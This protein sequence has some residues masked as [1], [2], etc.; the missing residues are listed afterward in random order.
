M[1][2]VTDSLTLSNA[3]TDVI[4]GFVMLFCAWRISR[5]LRDGSRE[6]AANL[7]DERRLW[8]EFFVFSAAVALLGVV[9]HLFVWP[10]LAER[11]LWVVLY[12]VMFEVPYLLMKLSATVAGESGLRPDRART[13]VF[14]GVSLYVLT[15]GIRLVTGKN[16]IRV[17]ILFAVI[18]FVYVTYFFVRGAKAKAVGLAWIAWAMV[19][20]LACLVLQVVRLGTFHFIWDLDCNGMAHLLLV[21]AVVLIYVGV[22]RRFRAAKTAQA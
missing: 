17:F 13:I 18:C 19:P 22:K 6:V 5:M 10:D 2:L 11:L 15:A 1:T 14:L 16:T 21:V 3:F 8:V 20:V 12:A 7:L 9:A 4:L